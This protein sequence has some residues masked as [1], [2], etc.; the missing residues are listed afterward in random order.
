MK[1]VTSCTDH[2]NH[3]KMWVVLRDSQS[4]YLLVQLVKGKITGRKRMSLRQIKKVLHWIY[5]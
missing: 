5:N 4:H 1:T 2:Y 3:W